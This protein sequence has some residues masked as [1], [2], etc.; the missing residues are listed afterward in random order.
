M[1]DWTFPVS[2]SQ[3]GGIWTGTQ[4]QLG[5]TVIDTGFSQ[6]KIRMLEEIREALSLGPRLGDDDLLILRITATYS[7]QIRED[8]SLDEY[9]SPQAL[10]VWEVG[11]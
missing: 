2:F 11:K 5:I 3:S 6:C 10:R 8:H 4:N 1:T 9:V 7:A